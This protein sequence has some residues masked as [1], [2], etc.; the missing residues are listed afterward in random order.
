MANRRF[1]IARKGA[2]R[3]SLSLQVLPAQASRPAVA[4][5]DFGLAGLAWESIVKTASFAD[6]TD[7]KPAAL[8]NSSRR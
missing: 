7:G 8:L 6:F 2:G 3:L 4:I 1:N 5:S